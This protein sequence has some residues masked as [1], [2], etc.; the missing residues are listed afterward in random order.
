MA[1]IIFDEIGHTYTNKRTG[2][3]I[4]SV[5]QVIGAVYG[6]GLENAPAEFVERAAAKGTK[7]H[8]EIEAFIK[9][10]GLPEQVSPE[11]NNFIVYANKNLRLDVYAKSEII[12][13]AKT[14]YGEVC[15]TT[16][17]FTGGI[18]LDYKTSKTATRKQ[19]D[20]WQ[21]QLSFYWYMLK[22]AGKS[23]LGA[24]ILHLTA[25][26]CEEIPLEYLGDAFVEETMRLY[27]E[28]KKAQPAPITTELQ[29]IEKS[30][31]EYFADTLERIKVMEQN[32]ESIKEAIRVEMEQRNI[33]DL[34]IGNVKITYIA[35]TKRKSFDSTRFKAEHADLYKAYQKESAVNSSIRIKVC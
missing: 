29:T 22:Q 18:L 24:K 27:S 14:P 20:K 10:E 34:Q 32:I 23:V 12:L 28:G 2:Q 5:T 3:I 21:K 16:D 1:D 8:K 6:S 35:P 11:T 9:G 13:H 30:D 19:I 4:P 26:G 7:I 17:L 33:L 15:G 25:D 31:L